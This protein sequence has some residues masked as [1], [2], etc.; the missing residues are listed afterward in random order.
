[1]AFCIST[2]I[3][4]KTFMAVETGVG[5][6]SVQKVAVFDFFQTTMCFSAFFLIS[7]IHLGS[8]LCAIMHTCAYGR[9]SSAGMGEEAPTCFWCSW[10]GACLKRL[11]LVFNKLALK[12]EGERRA[13]EYIGQTVSEHWSGKG[14]SRGGHVHYLLPSKLQKLIRLWK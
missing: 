14:G 12:W 11:G 4:S 3:Y 1:M 9:D 10:D 7:V 6:T 13:I 8:A 2:E 5:C